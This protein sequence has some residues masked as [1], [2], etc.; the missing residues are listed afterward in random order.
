MFH[1]L[2]W[3]RS[4]NELDAFRLQGYERL[5]GWMIITLATA[6]LLGLVYFWLS[7]RVVQVRQS[8]RVSIG[9]GGDGLLLQRIRAHANFAEYVPFCLILIGAIELSSLKPPVALP[10]VGAVLVVVRVAHAL[11]MA[12]DGAN[13]FR[14]VGAAGTWL[15][16]VGLSLWALVLAV[17]LTLQ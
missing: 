1:S 11:G 14:I 9:D 17:L 15:V 12:R 5:E 2:N 10:V 8:A 16:M 13:V 6:G 4:I 3:V 7:W